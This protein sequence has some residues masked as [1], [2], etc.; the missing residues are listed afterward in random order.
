MQT[1][2][3]QRPSWFGLHLTLLATG[4][5]LEM[6]SK[7]LGSVPTD[8][9][10]RHIAFDGSTYRNGLYNKVLNENVRNRMRSMMLNCFCELKLTHGNHLFI[11]HYSTRKEED[12]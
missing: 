12:I 8:A 9:P 10:V 6:V 3:K 1:G 4:Q 7:Y 5:S 11:F 2:K